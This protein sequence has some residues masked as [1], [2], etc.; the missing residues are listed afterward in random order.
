MPT[1]AVTAT[2]TSKTGWPDSAFGPGP[3][4][5]A[6][7]VFDSAGMPVH[8]TSSDDQC[9]LQHPVNDTPIEFTEFTWTDFGYDK[10][11]EETGNVNDN[12][13]QSYLDRQ[14]KFS[15]T[16]DFGCYIAQH[17]DGVMNNIVERLNKVAPITFPVPIVDEEGKFVGWAT[18]TLTKAT[19]GGRNGILTGYFQSG[20]QNQRLDVRGAGF[21]TSIFGG[22]YQLKLIN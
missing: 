2:A 9:D 15:L 16:L 12:D 10:L 17:N 7:K 11:C 18:F 13:L 20:L 1:W 8:C 5:V 3:F 14:A 19:A 21:G 6:K 22:T 4:I